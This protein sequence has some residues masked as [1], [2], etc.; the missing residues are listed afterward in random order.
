MIIPK[1]YQLTLKD[2]LGCTKTFDLNLKETTPISLEKHIHRIIEREKTETDIKISVIVYS[3]EEWVDFEVSF[4]GSLPIS[5]KPEDE[6]KDAKI[7][8]EI[9]FGSKEYQEAK[10]RYSDVYVMAM[11]SENNPIYVPKAI[12]IPKYWFDFTMLEISKEKS[13]MICF[14][15]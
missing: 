10:E 2:E 14:Y 9:F 15:R 5:G 7:L 8:A 4:T 13:Y 6:Q 12:P 1:N 3:F 11:D